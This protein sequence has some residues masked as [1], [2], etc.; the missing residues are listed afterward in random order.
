M[1]GFYGEIFL[2]NFRLIKEQDKK[3]K[4]CSYFA[5]RNALL[6]LHGSSELAARIAPPLKRD[7]HITLDSSH[8]H[9]ESRAANAAIEFEYELHVVDAA[10]YDHAATFS[11]LPPGRSDLAAASA[12]DG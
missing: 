9:R 6:L 8:Q 10:D 11:S 1:T 4:R 5:H 7:A 2:E 3:R 12:R